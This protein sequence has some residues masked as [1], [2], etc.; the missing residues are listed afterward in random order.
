MQPVLKIDLQLYKQ[1]LRTLL[2]GTKKKSEITIT[3]ASASALSIGSFYYNIYYMVK[4]V[5]ASIFSNELKLLEFRLK[6]LYDLVDYFVIIESV[7]THTGHRKPAHLRDNLHMFEQYRDKIIH[8]VLD[9]EMPLKSP[10]DVKPDDDINKVVVDQM[11][12]TKSPWLNENVQRNKIIDVVKNLN[13]DDTDVII[14]NDADEIADRNA[15][16]YLKRNPR[17][18]TLGQDVYYYDIN[19]KKINRWYHV[20]AITYK[21]FKTHTSLNTIRVFGQFPILFIGGWHLSYFG[22]VD[23]IR[24]KMKNM[25]HQEFNIPEYNDEDKIKERISKRKELFERDNEDLWFVEVYGN[26][27]LPRVPGLSVKENLDMLCNLHKQPEIE[28]HPN[29]R[30]NMDLDYVKSLYSMYKDQILETRKVMKKQHSIIKHPQYD[31]IEAEITTLLLLEFKPKRV[32]EFSPC[33]G[34]STAIILNALKMNTIHSYM[35][36]YDLNDLCK[37][38]I[39]CLDFKNVDWNFELGDVSKRFEDF[40]LDELDYLFIDSDHSAEFAEKY[41]TFVLEPLLIKCKDQNR[42]VVVSIHDVFHNRD[43]KEEGKVV[44]EFLSNHNIQYFTPARCMDNYL[45]LVEYRKTLGIDEYIHG[46]TSNP[47][48]F[49]ILG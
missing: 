27:Y 19:H 38:N 6:Y 28:T 36:S 26:N 4:I 49:F 43:V 12:S 29:L 30:V 10:E 21:T 7:Y 14:I 48:I 33:H 42:Q 25:C 41:I 34:W 17:D 24:N 23:F 20:K 13:L 37:R 3:Y 16:K 45:E 39:D 31:D 15:I 18:Y 40:N 5:D 46:S 9:E 2:R 8:Y 44:L 22:D 47:S 1:P 11:E 35:T 32:I